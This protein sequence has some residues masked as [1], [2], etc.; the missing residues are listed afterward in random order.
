MKRGCPRFNPPEKGNELTMSQEDYTVHITARH[1]EL[2]E[3]M[4]EYCRKKLALIHLDY[5]RIMEAKF[6]LDT[7]KHGHSAELVLYCANHVTLEA[8]T[9]TQ[10]LY[11][12]IDLTI[13]KIERQ[14]RKEKTNHLKQS[15]KS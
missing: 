14:M 1:M 11:E 9:E 5:P 15:G 3:P 4:R 8:A 6:V 2:T 13:D 10:N 12:A 7:T